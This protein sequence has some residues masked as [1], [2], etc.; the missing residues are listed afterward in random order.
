MLLR[1]GRVSPKSSSTWRKTHRQWLASHRLTDP[2]SELAYIDLLAA[3]DGLTA[4]KNALA[5]RPS[6]LA[7]RRGVVADPPP[8]ARH[9]RG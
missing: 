1:H 7:T 3:V 5:E 4:R 9:S 6:L 2:V 8:P